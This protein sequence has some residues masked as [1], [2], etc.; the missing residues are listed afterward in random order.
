MQVDCS[1]PTLSSFVTMHEASVLSGCGWCSFRGYM[2]MVRILYRG[3]EWHHHSQ[4]MQPMRDGEFEL[5]L[6]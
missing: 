3:M 2:V 5:Y 4:T 1:N 6:R